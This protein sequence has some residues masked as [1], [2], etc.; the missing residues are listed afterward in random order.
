MKRYPGFLLALLLILAPSNPAQAQQSLADRIRQ[1]ENSLSGNIIAEGDQAWSIQ[2]RMQ[3]YNIPA[4]TIAVVK[5]YKIDWAKAYGYADVNE[6][7][8]A[9]TDT[10][11]QA[12]SIS[13]S[14][15]AMALLRLAQEKKIDMVADINNYLSSWKFPYDSISNNKKI[16][17]A[18]LLSHTAGITIHGFPGYKTSDKL[19]SVVQVLNGEAPANTQAVRSQ[20]EPGLRSVYSGGGTT[21]SQL[22]AMDVSK[23]SYENFALS[24]VLRPIGMTH[25]FFGQHEELGQAKDLATGYY[26][27]G[28]EVSGK[29]HLY[30]E[31]GAAALWTTPTDLAKFMIETQL[32][33]QSKSNKV[34]SQEM[35]GLML[36][37]YIDKNAALG[38][39]VDD[40]A[41]A[42]KWFQHGGAN[43]AFRCLYYG[44]L[45][46]GNGAIVMI[47]S[48]NGAI[49]QEILNS[50]AQV[51]QWKN[52]YK[53]VVKKL[54]SMSDETA[55]SY[56]G[57]YEMG[58]GFILTIFME[59]GQMKG[60]ATGQGAL[61]IFPEAENRYFVKAANI[62]LEFDKDE[63][64]K[65]DKVNIFQNGGKVVAKRLVD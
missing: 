17:V 30:P 59:D 18:N 45:E 11:F 4:V 32:S 27:G 40:R 61:D 51:Y 48:E 22:L 12:A 53:P 13:K 65:V 28:G 43:E 42:G 57:K 46:G 47:N 34:L 33:L 39:F 21:I 44:S 25:S 54:F 26:A 19:P 14:L 37:P 63:K 3:L 38:V 8:L 16:S 62:V 60:Q 9:D 52:F 56:V 15:N 7:R 36:T 23:S 2:Q 24:K 35:T 1:V 6:Q 20:A 5:D 49:M 55:L 41:E 29:Y 10:R 58:P 64:G 50:V 31:L